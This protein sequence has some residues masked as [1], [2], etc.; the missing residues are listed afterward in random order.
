MR[1]VASARSQVC[2]EWK[3]QSLL[4]STPGVPV[5]ARIQS[6]KAPTIVSP[7]HLTLE[8]TQALIV[9]RRFGAVLKGFSGERACGCSPPQHHQECTRKMRSSQ[10]AGIRNCCIRTCTA[11]NSR[12]QAHSVDQE[13]APPAVSRS[14]G[15]ANYNHFTFCNSLRT[16]VPGAH[17][18]G[19]R[20][21]IPKLASRFRS[22][23]PSRSYSK[24]C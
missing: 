4:Y 14:A 10:V 18:Y 8:N 6:R 20:R 16:A 5:P 19:G 13:V 2:T 21:E 9:T 17:A 23:R 3:S 11:T 15:R 7:R 12:I 1:D 22:N 24:H